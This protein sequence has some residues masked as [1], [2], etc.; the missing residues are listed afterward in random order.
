[1]SESEINLYISSL[2][3]EINELKRIRNNLIKYF[4]LET[5]K[6]NI[7]LKDFNKFMDESTRLSICIQHIEETK[8]EFIRFREANNIKIF[9]SK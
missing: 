9:L 7:R 2:N 1:M 8:L 6:G 5:K 3:K 4:H